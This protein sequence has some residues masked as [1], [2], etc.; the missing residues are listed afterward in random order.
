MHI[1][2]LTDAQNGISR[3]KNDHILIKKVT[4]EVYISNKGHL[5]T[6]QFLEFYFDY[7]L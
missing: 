3:Q 7:L 6:Y 2:I 4:F 1:P 5:D